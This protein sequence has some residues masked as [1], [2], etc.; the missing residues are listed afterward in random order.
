MTLAIQG[1]LVWI[2]S[3][4]SPSWFLGDWSLMISHY[5]IPYKAVEIKAIVLK[6]LILCKM[7]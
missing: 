4:L 5:I 1:V 2:S 3:N 6:V 7:K